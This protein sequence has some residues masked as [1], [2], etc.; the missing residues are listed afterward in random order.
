MNEAVHVAFC[1]DDGYLEPMSVT[2]RSVARSLAGSGRE[3]VFHL[4]DGGLSESGQDR[5]R[6]LL[7]DSGD[8]VF[9][10]VPNPLHLPES[11]AQRNPKYTWW[12]SANL[13]RLQLADVVSPE[14]DRILYLDSDLIVLGDITELYDADLGGRPLGAVDA[15]R[16]P[17]HWAD[18]LALT[19][20]PRA[21]PPPYFNA[22][23]LLIDL[24]AWREQGLSE[25][26]VEFYQQNA[27]PCRSLD[28]DV[29]NVL[30]EN[31]WAAIDPKWNRLVQH[32]PD[33]PFGLQKMDHLAAPDGIVHFGGRV[34]PWHDDYPSTPLRSIYRQFSRFEGV[35]TMTEQNRTTAKPLARLRCDSLADDNG[36][37]PS[38]SVEPVT[39]DGFSALAFDGRSGRLATDTKLEADRSFTV[40]AWVRL[41]GERMDGGH[42]LRSGQY[43]ATAVSQSDP[44][45][46]PFYLGVRV[47]AAFQ[48][49]LS[50]KAFLRWTFT[51]APTD[52]SH[53]GAID[54]Q[55]A[56]SAL[57]IQP[58]DIGEWTFIAGVLNVPERTAEVHIPT[59]DDRGTA[60]LPSFWP[61]WRA[62][63]EIQVGHAFYL[64]EPSD[65]WPGEVAEV[66]VF[67]EAL[68]AAD[69]ADLRAESDPR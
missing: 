66:Q 29:L 12:T 59:R 6:E 36:L 67:Q 40:A 61:Y 64:G 4:I 46:S 7:R 42:R 9:C 58:R 62:E 11:H 68:S 10:P 25:R 33:D 49:D 41:N 16:R 28:Q 21:E 60:H 53:F 45:H 30:F 55:H 65:F 15:G 69:I 44:D 20:P 38:G 57:A 22:G 34:K 63:G 51:A 32:H 39:V 19:G 13:R 23:V 56:S 3:P 18:L 1:V 35:S 26:A 50:T 17:R 14:V 43:A 37:R 24:A 2:A 27:D 5:A 31:G 47:F 8:M 54:W 52:G 48:Y